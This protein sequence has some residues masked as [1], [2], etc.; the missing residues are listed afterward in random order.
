[1]SVQSVLMLKACGREEQ[2]RL[3]KRSVAC[4]VPGS[5][6]VRGVTGTLLFDVQDETA[7]GAAH[8]TRRAAWTVTLASL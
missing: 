1:M 8:A 2:R 5:F 3:R 6:D 7:L 4:V